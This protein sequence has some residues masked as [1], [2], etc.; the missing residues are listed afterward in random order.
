MTTYQVD[1]ALEYRTFAHAFGEPMDY[2]SASIR[3]DGRVLAVG[4]DRGVVLWD[5]A[6]GTELAF[7][8][9]GTPG[10]L[11]FEASG[12]LLTSGVD[13]RAAVAGSARPGP[14]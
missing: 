8:P 6:R 5:L 13:R 7:L 3:R 14:G 1:P 10:T 2:A 9:I 11:M 4:T 12:D